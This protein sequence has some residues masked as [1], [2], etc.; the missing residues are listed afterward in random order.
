MLN[1][2]ETTAYLKRLGI[3]DI[4]PPSISYLRKLQ[5]AH[6]ENISWQTIDIITGR[7]MPID[8]HSSVQLMTGGRSGYCFH[9]NGAFGELLRTLGFNVSWHRAGVQPHGQEP[10][11]NSFHLGLTVALVTEQQEEE[12]WIADVGLGDMP[13]GPL[14]VRSGCYTQGPFQ[15]QVVPSTIDP[16]GWRMV[17]DPLGSSVGVDYEREGLQSIEEFVPKHEMYS[18]SPESPWINLFLVRNRHAQGSN[19]LRGCIWKKREG[20]HIEKTEIVTKSKWLEVLG[21]VFHEKLI[22]YS[23]MERDE[24]WKRVWYLHEQW[25]KD[26]NGSHM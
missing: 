6:M 25:K 1:S 15:Y 3:T 8:L 2:E 24:L 20:A 17:H 14:P 21:D 9:L 13:Y 23:P 4:E 10:R 22:H 18:L 5:Q 26:Q 12:L 11:I 19:E 7:P 16:S